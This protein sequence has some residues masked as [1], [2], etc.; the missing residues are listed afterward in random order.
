M[1]YYKK[2]TRVS[3]AGEIEWKIRE[4]FMCGLSEQVPESFQEL[5]GW[6]SLSFVDMG[7]EAVF[8]KPPPGA[9]QEEREGSK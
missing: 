8:C 2:G 4:V 9:E 5:L 7:K 1:G 3:G 6:S